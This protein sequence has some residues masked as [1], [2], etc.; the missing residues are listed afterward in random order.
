MIYP[1]TGAAKVN[2]LPFFTRMLTFV[3]ELKLAGNGGCKA[4][5]S[6]FRHGGPL[7][8]SGKAWRP[9]MPYVCWLH[10]CAVLV[11]VVM[12]IMLLA[13][14]CL[15]NIDAVTLALLSDSQEFEE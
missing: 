3:L 15:K 1:T 13:K 11:V 6:F 5:R 12:P 10:P 9:A 7:K 2:V 14:V 8:I 4:W